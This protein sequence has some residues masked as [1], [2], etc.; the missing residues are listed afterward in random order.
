VRESS[1]MG[2]SLNKKKTEVIVTSKKETDIKSRIKVEGTLLKQVTS[3]K[4]H[5]TNV[6]LQTRKHVV[7][8]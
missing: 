7:H 2:L 4:Y 1:K 5:V 6:S 8:T 3:F